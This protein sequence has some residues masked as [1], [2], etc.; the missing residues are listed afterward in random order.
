MKR[1]EMIQNF[2]SLIGCISHS[3]TRHQTLSPGPKT[4]KNIV[5]RR[6]E[7]SNERKETE[8]KTDFFFKNLQLLNFEEKNRWPRSSSN[9]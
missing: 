1:F 8:K 5:N 7:K 9:L 2:H 3:Q 4:D 6:L